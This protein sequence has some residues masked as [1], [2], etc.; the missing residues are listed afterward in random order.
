MIVAL[1]VGLILGAAANPRGALAASY[2]PLPVSGLSPADSQIAAPG[3]SV[4][5]QLD[6]SS[7]AWPSV[8]SS[9]QGGKFGLRLAWGGSIE[10]FFPKGTTY[11]SGT[12]A[13]SN[14]VSFDKSTAIVTARPSLSLNTGYS[15]TLAVGT[16]LAA[17][18][19]QDLGQSYSSSSSLCC[20]SSWTFQSAT[21]SATSQSQSG[22]NPTVNLASGT[23]T[24]TA[25]A[26]GT[27][28]LTLAAYQSD[29]VSGTAG[30][31]TPSTSYTDL[32]AGLGNTFSSVTLSLSGLTGPGTAYW[33]NG[34]SWK[35][36]SGQ[37][38][39]SGSL[40]ITL[41]SSSS[42]AISQLTGT[43]IA[44]VPAPAVT[45]LT[46]AQGPTVGNTAV[47]ISGSGFTGATQVL[48]G[49][50]P[51]AQFTVTSDS[52]ISAVSTFGT[53]GPVDVTVQTPGGTS[54]TG[55][56]DQFTYLSPAT[57]TSVSPTSGLTSGGTAVT[58]SGS[59]FT[60]TTGVCFGS[61]CLGQSSF[62]VS[63]DGTQITATAPSGSASVDVTVN[64]P[65]GT[66]PRTMADRFTYLPNLITNGDF[67]SG[68]T[69]WTTACNN[70]G[71]Y[72]GQPLP[73]S[74]GFASVSSSGITLDSSRAGAP[75][76][77][78]DQIVAAPADSILTGTVTV[79]SLNS[80]AD[81]GV[82]LSVTLLDAGR[83][84]IGATLDNTSST[85]NI[86]YG[87][88]PYA[89]SSGC[90]A[91]SW[92][93]S[94]TGYF[95]DMPGWI[96]GA[97]PQQFTMDIGSIVDQ[98]LSGI[99]ASRVAYIRVQPEVYDD[100]AAAVATFTNL[101]LTTASPVRNGD[102][103]AGLSGW[104]TTCNEW[105]S[106]P[107]NG[108]VDTACGS[109]ASTSSSGLTLDTSTGDYNGAYRSASQIVPA[110]A[111]SLLTGTVTVTG[112]SECADNGAWVTAT[113]LD[114]SQQSLGTI[115]LQHHPYTSCQPAG[116]TN[117]PTAYYQEMPSWTAGA[118][119]QRFAMPIGSIIAE[120]LSG[121]DPSK[122]SY[123][124]IQLTAYHDTANPVVTFTNLRLQ[125]VPL[126]N[127]STDGAAGN[128]T[129][130]DT[131]AFRTA[132]QQLEPA[133][134]ILL[135]PPGTYAVQPDT[136]TIPSNVTVDG[137][138]A[139]LKPATPGYVLL[140][141]QGTDVTVAGLTLEGNNAVTR[142]MNID[143]T[144]TNALLTHVTVQDV[145][146]S[147]DSTSTLYFATP[148]GLRV[149]GNTDQVQI[150]STTVRNVSAVRGG[151]GTCNDRIARGILVS[152]SLGQL[153]GR[154]VTIEYSSV[155]QVTPKDDGDCIVAQDS[156][157][158]ANLTVSH[159]SFDSC[160]KR[161]IKIQ[162]PGA[163]VA[164]NTIDNP[165]Q[166]NNFTTSR[167][168]YDQSQFPYDMYAAISVYKD[169][170]MV[171]GNTING[172]GSF[173]N[174]IEIGDPCSTLNTVTVQN[175]T[176]SM[177][178]SSYTTGASLI[179]AMGPVNG[180]T[181]TGNQGSNAGYGITVPPNLAAQISGNTFT[182]VTSAINDYQAPCS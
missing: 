83:N 118:G 70:W 167:Y 101:T 174:G 131:A 117:S 42:P 156:D 23:T 145:T 121:V 133:G 30:T 169:N 61:S 26:S 46:P 27:G 158:A 20:A 97:G 140:E 86:V 130:D 180:L 143:D 146:E 106:S 53:H 104:T 128:G 152:P 134:G 175:N 147:S 89:G 58:I 173:Y 59:G 68:M 31:L 177:G 72:G 111:S 142:G 14:A 7:A 43:V 15:A 151:C 179:R 176:V 113:L 41:S 182:N 60:G 47:T 164:N 51:A 168:G 28:T 116:Y 154:D 75:Y 76:A 6:T 98:H 21:S 171:S 141:L 29:P 172:A 9:F 92:Q 160:A 67:S 103:S 22:V 19:A 108:A 3:A 34:Q 63:G 55:S 102:F 100:T 78:V 181:I 38:Y 8:N 56:S 40:I 65:G 148:I 66:S 149:Y 157:D 54:V 110:S 87:H 109:Y 33:W 155:S 45:G 136:L 12:L 48:F 4:Q 32:S 25:A 39:S 132:I 62:S 99:D 64:G 35:L 52:Q 122:V 2:T 93:N 162:V 159:S 16:A 17:L 161:A 80:C 115:Q 125:N 138:G 90:S 165:Y 124:K 49:R 139:T 77:G 119:P 85:G 13:V 153:V 163:V 57:M 105:G 95:Q 144:S 178:A 73:C 82:W 166:G 135:I 74:T 11:S 1:V 81:N 127:V 37:S 84:P 123:I 126:A 112:M 79:N 137:Y 129:S 88:H 5:V 91:A 150:D 96:A 10:W 71:S 114:A 170:V 36:V 94:S 69:G 107:W 120:H 18:V 44:T 24:Q 50:A